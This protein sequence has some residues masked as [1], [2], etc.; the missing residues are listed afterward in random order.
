MILA[1]CR[2]LR[3]PRIAGFSFIDFSIIIG[4][5]VHGENWEGSLASVMKALV[6]FF[7]ICNGF[8]ECARL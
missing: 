3:S 1:R 7:M 2:L 4:V 8:L 6:S 5:A